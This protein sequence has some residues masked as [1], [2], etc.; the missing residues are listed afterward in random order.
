MAIHKN[1]FKTI[2]VLSGKTPVLGATAEEWDKALVGNMRQSL[3]EVK[4]RATSG[5][6]RDVTK[7]SSFDVATFVG[8]Q[9]RSH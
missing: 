9:I 6:K 8:E 3:V 2:T 4:L 5:V 1:R 7:A